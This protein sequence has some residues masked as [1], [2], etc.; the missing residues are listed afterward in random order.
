MST[1]A[2]TR[3]A[4]RLDVLEAEIGSLRADVTGLADAMIRLTRIVAV[5]DPEA[6][7]K[8]VEAPKARKARK[9]PVTKGSQVVTKGGLSRQDWN[10]T[11]MTKLALAGKNADGESYRSIALAVWPLVV[12]DRKAGRTPDE[13]L[14]RILGE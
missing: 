11:L 1:T 10:N 6:P 7:A 2:T 3:N 12:A 9:A 5:L 8:Q 4:A 13:T 14:A